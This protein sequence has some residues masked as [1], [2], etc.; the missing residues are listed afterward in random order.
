ML[1]GTLIFESSDMQS[2][3]EALTSG[4]ASLGEVPS[5]LKLQLFAMEFP[6][7]GKVLAAIV[8][9]ASD[10]HAEGRKLIDKVVTF[11][12]CIVNATEAKTTAQYGQDNEKLVTYG[13]YG[14]SYT[15]NLKKWTPTSVKILAKYSATVPS[16][17]VMIWTHSL[18]TR[19]STAHET[20]VFGAR[21]DHHVIEIVSMTTDPALQ[22][23][24]STWGQGLLMELKEH[25]DQANILDSAY[26]PLLD[27]GDVDL[28][29]IYGRHLDTIRML[30]KKYDPQNVFK[31][32]APRM[33]V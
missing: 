20:S 30:K 2:T 5:A 22:E 7:L 1:V 4:I 10:D 12:K 14:R 16:G 11:G 27:H 26:L 13:V 3:W 31:Y 6:G 18:R 21:E 8:T 25:E 29:K 24:A 33:I 23:T 17:N 9:W 28:Q 32:A 15:L 19:D